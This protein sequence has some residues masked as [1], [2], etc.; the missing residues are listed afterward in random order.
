MSATPQRISAYLQTELRKRSIDEVAAV[1]AAEWL[2]EASLLANS[3][4]RPGLPL[5]NLLRKGLIAGQEQRPPQRY[6][7]WFITRA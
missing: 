3:E 5:R 4:S 7:R 1:E 2:D 6:G